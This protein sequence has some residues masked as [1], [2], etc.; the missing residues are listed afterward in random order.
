MNPLGPLFLALFYGNN[1]EKD[2]SKK[3][4]SEI[5]CDTKS[6]LDYNQFLINWILRVSESFPRLLSLRKNLVFKSKMRNGFI[7]SDYENLKFLATI[8]TI[9]ALIVA[10]ISLALQLS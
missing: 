6:I 9:V 5:Q 2:A 7:S 4:L 1:Q 8:S 10:V 3:L